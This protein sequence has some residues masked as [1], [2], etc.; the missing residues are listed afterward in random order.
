MA[1]V[2]TPTEV[3]QSVENSD[4]KRHMCLY[5]E[6]GQAIE[7]IRLDAA[8]AAIHGNGL[9]YIPWEIVPLED[10]P[11]IYEKMVEDYRAAIDCPTKRFPMWYLREMA[12]QRAEDVFP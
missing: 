4:L 9:I 1:R 11:S 2:L 3:R 8:K 6:G 12:R 10:I 7:V 5:S